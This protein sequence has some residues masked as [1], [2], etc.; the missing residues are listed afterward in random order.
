MLWGISCAG[1]WNID[2]HLQ[3]LRKTKT[4]QFLEV[5]ILENYKSLRIMTESPFMTESK[6]Y[7][8]WIA[9]NKAITNAR[10]CAV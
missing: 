6:T 4:F 3:I 8:D 10:H 7:N 5:E 9:Q 2:D 1:Y